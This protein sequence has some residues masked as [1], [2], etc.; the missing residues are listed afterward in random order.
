MKVKIKSTV[1]NGKMSRNRNELSKALTQFEGMDIHISIEKAK[2]TR[3][4]PQNAYYHGCV[5]PLIRMGLKDTTG[6]TYSN[7]QVHDLMKTRFLCL[8]VHLRD[9]EFMQAIRSTT[10]LSTFDFEEYMEN[11]RAFALEFLG[12][13]IALPNENIK[14][15]F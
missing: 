7:E 4:T 11:C 8:D 15:E 12:V 6:D 9:G 1:T 13:T 3:S 14:L 2:K 10:E 5:I